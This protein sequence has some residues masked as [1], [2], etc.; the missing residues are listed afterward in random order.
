[1]IDKYKY[2]QLISVPESMVTYMKLASGTRSF[3]DVATDEQTHMFSITNRDPTLYQT[4]GSPAFQVCPL[5]T[6]HS[7]YWKGVCL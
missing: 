7:R 3:M 5:Y 1:M 6:Y 4:E 2:S